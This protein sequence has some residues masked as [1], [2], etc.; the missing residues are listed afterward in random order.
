MIKYIFTISIIIIT[1][2]ITGIFFYRTGYLNGREWVNH[3][4]R[5]S[6]YYKV[7]YQQ[8]RRAFLN[9]GDKDIDYPNS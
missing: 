8:Y 9:K 4:K 2:T 3:Y 5:L 1:N 6:E 7:N